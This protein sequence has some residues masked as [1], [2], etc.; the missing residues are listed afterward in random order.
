VSVEGSAF[1]TLFFSGNPAEIEKIV[2]IGT[3]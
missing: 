2:E 3:L 1:G